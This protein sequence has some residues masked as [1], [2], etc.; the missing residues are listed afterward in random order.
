M[1]PADHVKSSVG[2]GDYSSAPCQDPQQLHDGDGF[3]PARSLP[4]EAEAG[5]DGSAA[6]GRVSNRQRGPAVL[7]TRPTT[8]II[9]QE[10]KM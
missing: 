4:Q 2:L 3:V 9:D 10:E 8:I 6:A 7:T 1:P 5:I